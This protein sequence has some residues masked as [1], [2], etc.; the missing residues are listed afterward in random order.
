MLDII[1]VIHVQ[2]YEQNAQFYDLALYNKLVKGVGNYYRL[3]SLAKL[4]INWDTH[5]GLTKV[6]VKVLGFTVYYQVW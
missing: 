2:Y 3:A 5:A 1:P 4:I 6:K